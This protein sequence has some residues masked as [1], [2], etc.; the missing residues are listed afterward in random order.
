M[1][2]RVAA[3]A[4]AAGIAAGAIALVASGA[5]GEP[6]PAFRRDISVVPKDAK[7]FRGASLQFSTTPSMD[8][9]DV[10][11]RWGLVGPGSIDPTGLYHSADVASASAV[12]IA[13]GLRFPNPGS[14][15][16]TTVDPPSRDTPVV[17]TTCYED[18]TI[19]VN[20]GR[21]LSLAGAFTVG[22]RTAGVVIDPAAR[23]AIFAV[24]S[25]LA[26]VDLTS[27]RWQTSAPIAG[28]RFS[29]VAL[30]AGGF[31]ATTDNE[32]DAGHPGVRVFRINRFG[33]PVLV[34]SVAAGETPE[35]IAVADDGR[36]FFVTNI[37]SNS[38]MR[39]SVD[40]RGAVRPTGSARTASRPFGVAVDPVH[41][42]LFVA[43]ND[44]A[45]IS[46]PGAHPGLERFRLPDMTRVG[47]IISTGSQASL[48]LGVAVDPSAARL[49]VTNE[50]EADIAVFSIPALRR[51]ATLPT[52]LTPWLPYLDR[53]HHRLYVPN[54]RRDSF[55]LYDTLALRP[56]RLG[57]PTC[58]YPTSM[59][60]FDP[61]P[62]AASGR[63]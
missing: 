5:H 46:G 53:S 51:V 2:R 25:Q 32:A 24:D 48:P 57:V 40:S 34:S 43:D 41:H 1:T 61:R 62:T 17:I 44:T 16:V 18:G 30:L 10:A 13:G 23:R 19:N 47:D 4:L 55:G 12:V 37:N 39:F 22:G 7:V 14:V 11:I 38:V 56:L 29:E 20:D 6:V 8:G 28:A 58:A 33:R 3:T 45:T 9:Q 54:A 15:T 36:S 59:A 42:L 63:R 60:V 21:D 50:G 31:V 35:G 49:F 26:A 52:G 27:M